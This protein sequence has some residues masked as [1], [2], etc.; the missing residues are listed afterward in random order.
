MPAYFTIGHSTRSAAEFIE[1]LE[2]AGVTHLADVRAIPRSRTNPQFNI[3]ALPVELARHG[4]AYEHMPELGGRRG[5]VRADSPN[6]FW[7]HAS[8]RNYADYAA[9]AAFRAGLERLRALGARRPTAIMCAEAVWWRCHRRII[10]DYLIAAG[11]TVL[12]IL[13]PGKVEPAKF[14]PAAQRRPGGTLV[15]PKEQPS[16]L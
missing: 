10:A 1:L 13:G 8:F 16:L 6:D 9:T 2:S 7:Q 3:D 12:H 14:T 11:E 5:R 15:Y 4:I